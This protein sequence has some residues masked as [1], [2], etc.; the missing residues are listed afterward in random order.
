MSRAAALSARNLVVRRGTGRDAFELR[1]DALELHPGETLAVLGPNGAGKSTLL[2]RL[3]PPR[4]FPLLD[5]DF[6]FFKIL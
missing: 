2:P 6:D 1:V 4:E 5:V 3:I